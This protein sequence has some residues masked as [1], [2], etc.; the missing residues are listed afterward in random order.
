[1]PNAKKNLGNTPD[2]PVEENVS[3]FQTYGNPSKW[4]L[5]CKA[6]SDDEGWMKST[7]VMFLNTGALVQVTTQQRQPH[8]GHHLAEALTFCPGV[9]RS[10][11]KDHEGIVPEKIGK[12]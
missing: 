10:S 9:T 2:S 6:W 4:E 3:D 12:S 7:K 5:L 1:M 11:F 8:G